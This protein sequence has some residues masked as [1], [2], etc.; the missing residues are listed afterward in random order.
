M[1]ILDEKKPSKWARVVS[2]V[3][4]AAGWITAALKGAW[5][6]A[7]VGTAFGVPVVIISFLEWHLY[8]DPDHQPNDVHFET[9]WRRWRL[10]HRVFPNV[11]RIEEELWCDDDGDQRRK[12][13]MFYSDTTSY[14]LDHWEAVVT[15]NPKKIQAQ[16]HIHL[17]S[18]REQKDL[19][20]P[21]RPTD[22][23]SG[24]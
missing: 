13:L 23:T 15:P 21:A 4:I 14:A 24:N 8:V 3:L 6:Y 2:I 5:I 19:A 9:R 1:F 12:Q 20:M 11:Q 17:S 10:T 18:M 7:L 16:W 22:G